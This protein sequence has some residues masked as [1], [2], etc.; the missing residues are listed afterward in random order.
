MSEST[1][2]KVKLLI[3]SH[4]SGKSEWLYNYLIEKSRKEDDKNKIDLSK[5]IYLV[6]PEQDTNDKQR[7]I[8]KKI[9]EKGY[10]AGIV[11]ID[12]VSFDRIAHNVFDILGIE[13]DK[14]KVIDDDVKTMIL[15]I[16]LSRLE[17]ESNGTNKKDD[18]KL[19]YCNNMS[20]KIGF[21]EKL[22]KVV[23]EFY[24]YEVTDEEINTVVKAIGENSF[25]GKKLKDFE[26]IFNEFKNI[27]KSLNLSISEDKYDLLNKS[28]AKVDMFNDS[29]VA[30]DGFTGFTPIQ[31]KILKQIV[32]VC[33]ETYVTVDLRN[34]MSINYDDILNSKL[35]IADV[36]YLSKKTI[37]DIA[38]KLDIKYKDFINENIIFDNVFK[39]E[40]K[41][42]LLLL[43]NYLYDSSNDN[44]LRELRLN[45]SV[46]NIEVYSAK[47]IEEEV[48]NAVQIIYDYVRNKDYKYEDIKIIVPNIDDYKDT[49]LRYF[50]LYQIPLFIDDSDSIINSPYIETVVSALKV[51][52]Y[53]FTYDSVMRYINSGIFTKNRDC[54]IFD[55]FIKE[56][57]FRGYKRYLEGFDKIDYISDKYKEKILKQRDKFI[58]PLLHLKENIDNIKEIN[59]ESYIDAVLLFVNEVNIEGRISNLL[60]NID[61]MNEDDTILNKPYIYIEQSKEIFKSVIKN[62]LLI[63]ENNEFNITFDEFIRVFETGFSSKKLRTIPFAI[64]QVVVGDIMRSRFD[65]PKIE[66]FLGLNQSSVP[67]RTNDTAL[68]DDAIRDA[69]ANNVKELSQTTIET[70]FNQRFYI[71][72]ALTN[73]IDKLILSYPN[74][75]INNDSDVKSSVLRMIEDLFIKI[76]DK[77][78]DETRIAEKKID[79]SEFTLY[80]K[81][82]IISFI[83]N[84]INDL[85]KSYIKEND[86]YKYDF[87]DKTM[88][89]I[90]KTKKY[91]EYLKDDKKFNSLLTNQFK[92]VDYSKDA[93]IKD[94]LSKK[95][96]EDFVGSP[97][98]LETFSDCPLKFF[99]KYNLNVNKRKEYEVAP[100]DLGTVAHKVFEKIFSGNDKSINEKN[101]KSKVEIEFDNAINELKLFNEFDKKDKKYFGVNRLEYVK[102]N[103]KKLIVEA[104]KI[105][106]NLTKNSNYVVENEKE[107]KYDIG[108]DNSTPIYVKGK[109][110]RIEKVEAKGATYVSVIDYKTGKSS[111]KLDTKEMDDG[112]S[113]QLL[114]YLDNLLN[115]N[116]NKDNVEFCGSFYFWVANPI[117][118]LG[119][120]DFYDY[121]ES[122]KNSQF[123]YEGLTNSD[124]NVL[125]TVYGEN[126]IDIEFKSDGKAIKN[127]KF[128]DNYK[129]GSVYLSKN[130]LN[131]KIT[132]MHGKINENIHKLKNGEVLA[133]PYNEKSC[134]YCDYRDICRNEKNYDKF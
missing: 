8:M 129:L 90:I 126:N 115:N 97:T 85:R 50:N 89:N 56:H 14:Q 65:N 46:E 120:K 1:G 41:K 130:E 131:K 27:L 102:E 39:Y 31:L 69:F 104:S 92:K 51:L 66:F 93:F 13:P 70:A 28:I 48:Q 111:K 6:V 125:K 21:A 7:L 72:L 95:L 68:I 121:N 87:D 60:K 86:K 53:G 76:N 107:F 11:N 3:G 127:V 98:T 24:S 9:K 113:I 35:D 57:G 78:E 15:A 38:M 101:I 91:I 77:S 29:I 36:F 75:D 74:T 79:I 84:N 47:N 108:S 5:K 19:L 114:L 34:P 40:D 99:L 58:L 42:D 96:N 37:K 22:T 18:R 26:L 132:S 33:S 32:D 62:I 94:S 30:F 59:L 43:E 103:S 110:D 73:P 123:G 44:K 63:D 112:H 134:K 10:G 80:R 52:K 23:S 45:T 55:N 118:K 133:I 105:L 128:N 122:E 124:A 88:S 109:I 117:K 17:K 106:L 81:E 4:G 49:I 116:E 100:F 2:Q 54:Y 67:A 25:E 20:K 61:D 16:V 64:D 82:D 12:V 71:Y 83:S 119:F